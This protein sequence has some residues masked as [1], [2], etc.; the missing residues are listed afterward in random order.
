[1]GVR[2]YF[3][4][5]EYNHDTYMAYFLKSTTNTIKIGPAQTGN[6][7]ISG[8]LLEV[9]WQ[10]NTLSFYSKNYFGQSVEG[11]NQLNMNGVTYQYIGVIETSIV[12]I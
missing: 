3:G 6:S 11:A 2:E 5:V 12:Q 8:N 7:N 9:S 4:S 10:G 1:M